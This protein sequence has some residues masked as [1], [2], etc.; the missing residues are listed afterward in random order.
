MVKK[1]STG[2]IMPEIIKKSEHQELDFDFYIK[3]YF[4]TLSKDYIDLDVDSDCVIT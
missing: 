3:F 1:S 4:I 2:A